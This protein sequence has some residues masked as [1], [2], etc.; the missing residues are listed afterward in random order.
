MYVCLYVCMSKY[1]YV[2]MHVFYCFLRIY[3]MNISIAHL[4]M[5]SVCMSAENI[6]FFSYLLRT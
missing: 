4:C 6:H 2:C 5:M 1:M 3:V